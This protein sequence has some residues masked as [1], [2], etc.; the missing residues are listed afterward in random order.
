LEPNLRGFQNIRGFLREKNSWS[1]D[2]SGV[3]N[4]ITV[5]MDAPKKCTAIFKKRLLIELAEFTVTETSKGIIL[6]WSTDAE[7]DTAGFHLWQAKP[8]QEECSHFSKYSD[9]KRLTE[10]PIQATGDLFSEAY[11]S[12][13]VEMSDMRL[14]YCFGLEE[15]DFEGNRSFYIIGSGIDGRIELFY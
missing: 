6:E 12:Y 14:D 15:I 4:P 13:E 1:G 9:V 8:Y 10:Q 3:A 7:R 11:Y 5:E 2:C